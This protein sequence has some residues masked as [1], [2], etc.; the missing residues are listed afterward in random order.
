MIGYRII[1]FQPK[2]DDLHGMTWALDKEQQSYLHLEEANRKDADSELIFRFII[3]PQKFHFSEL[4]D[5]ERIAT[6]S[7]HGLF[8][9]AGLLSLSKNLPW[10][11]KSKG[12]YL[13]SQRVR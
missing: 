1:S 8:R 5:I 10:M 9:I 6:H 7:N 4:M 2:S 11:L 3:S 13:Y 12:S